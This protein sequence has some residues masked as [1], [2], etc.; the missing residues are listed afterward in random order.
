MLVAS[1]DKRVIGFFLRACI[2]N[3]AIY[4]LALAQSQQNE[5]DIYQ[6]LTLSRIETSGSR[7]KKIL[8]SELVS[9][10]LLVS[11]MQ[12]PTLRPPHP[13]SVGLLIQQK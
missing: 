13:T 5:N 8:G 1:A 12:L 11:S 10:S 2:N 4:R 9:L 6:V 3:P 7:L